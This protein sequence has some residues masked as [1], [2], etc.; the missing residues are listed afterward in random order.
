MKKLALLFVLILALVPVFVACDDKEP[1]ETETE[2]EFTPEKLAFADLYQTTLADNES[3]TVAEGVEIEGL[4]NCT[5]SGYY[6]E[7]VV[8]TG[9]TS[10]PGDVKYAVFNTETGKVVYTLTREE[11]DAD[12]IVSA[13]VY[14]YDDLAFIREVKEVTSSVDGSVT[15]T[16]TLY[17][18]SGKSIATKE[19]RDF[20]M[21]SLS[22]D[23]LALDGKVYSVKDKVMT[24]LFELG[25][26]DIPYCDVLTDAYNYADEDD[27]MYVYDQMFDLVTYV[28]ADSNA[29]DTT[30]F[31]LNDGNILIASVY[32]LLDEAEEYDYALGIEKFNISYTIFDVETEVSTDIELDFVIQ[33][34]VNEYAQADEFNKVF[35]EGALNNL[36]YIYP[37][38][39][40]TV[41]YTYSAAEFVNLD[42]TL[43]VVGVL[44]DV[45]P[46]QAP[47]FPTLVAD[48]RFVVSNMVGQYFLLD[49][50]GAVLGEVTGDVSGDYD[51]LFTNMFVDGIGNVYDLNLETVFNIDSADYDQYDD[52][53][54]KDEFDNLYLLTKT[55]YV[56]LNITIESLD[57][58]YTVGDT[59]VFSTTI[60]P[61]GGDSE[62]YTTIVNELGASVF[63]RQIGTKNTEAASIYTY[64]SDISAVDGGVM[65][66]VRTE[67]Y[68]YVTYETVTTYKTYFCA[69]NVPA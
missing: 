30:F 45:I 52:I 46:N 37:I 42:D 35:V 60:Y 51:D 65:I 69:D 67:T 44:A 57:N 7:L 68:S 21:S 12:T 16:Y 22:N 33:Y 53:L 19:G 13:Y 62:S 6:N 5:Y 63:K 20:S 47:S 50:T 58:Y 36:A 40:K 4:L 39:D 49:E 10:E 25:L 61:E 48:N 54:Y 34:L 27:I 23:L 43:T 8:Y 24:E 15:T 26:K 66:T 2:T 17:D 31:V 14:S 55:G 1:V 29:D 56:A 18:A 11:I 38:V 3:F 32:Q 28:E 9:T 41:D 64:L 59:Y